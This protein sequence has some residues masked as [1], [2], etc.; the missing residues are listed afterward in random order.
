MASFN[1][2][3]R[4]S[5][6][7]TYPAGP[8]AFAAGGVIEDCWVL[9]EGHW[10][11]SRR[12]GGG[13]RTRIDTSVPGSWAGGLPRVDAAVPIAVELL[14]PSAFLRVPWPALARLASDH[15]VVAARLTGAARAEAAWAERLPAR[16]GPG[17]AQ[18][19]LAR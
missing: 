14:A 7:A 16:P 6:L 13:L 15:P 1:L 19:M 17:G 3:L 18:A 8:A 10:R 4:A 11:V 2:R 12:F 5:E 9:L